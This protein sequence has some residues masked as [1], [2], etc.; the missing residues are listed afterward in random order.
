[1][2]QWTAFRKKLP[3]TECPEKLSDV[4]P[5]LAEFLLPI[6]RTK[7]HRSPRSSRPGETSSC[8]THDLGRKNALQLIDH[9]DVHGERLVIT[10][11][12]AGGRKELSMLGA[13]A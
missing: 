5:V 4:V 8:A 12:V 3:N 2:A 13:S 6:A 1:M 7:G 10:P 9:V 11:K